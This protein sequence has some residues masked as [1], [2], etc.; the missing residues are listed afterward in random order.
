MTARFVLKPY[1]DPAEGLD[2]EEQTPL[3]HD[4]ISKGITDRFSNNLQ[5]KLHETDHGIGADFP[6]ITLELIGT[7]TGLF[8]G[9]PA[10]HK[11]IREAISEW[12]QIK[13]EISKFISW[14]KK[15][16]PVASYS[17]EVAFY[18][19]I[20]YLSTFEDVDNFELTDVKEFVGKTGNIKARFESAL[21]AYY[22]LAFADDAEW[23]HIFLYDSRLKRHFYKKVPLD[24]LL[25]GERSV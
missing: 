11:K 15:N 13:D 17:I 14:I 6:T 24:P 7:A 16:E 10:L 18:E 19:A 25:E 1:S 12:R 22:F 2:W 8:F 9:I 21:I 4:R 23:L 3:H 20:N 5:F